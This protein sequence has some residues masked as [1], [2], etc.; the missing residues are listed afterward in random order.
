MEIDVCLIDGAVPALARTVADG[1]KTKVSTRD[2][3]LSA[4]EDSWFERF[5]VV[6]TFRLAA[7]GK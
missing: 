5:E 6:L 3:G 7:H 2:H 1:A 4:S